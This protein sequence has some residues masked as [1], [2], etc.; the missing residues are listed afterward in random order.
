MFNIFKKG[1]KAKESKGNLPEEEVVELKKERGSKKQE[2]KTKE[3]EK[4]PQN[5]QQN[6]IKT[7]KLEKELTK[8]WRPR[9]IDV[10]KTF[11]KDEIL[12]SKTDTRGNLT[13]GNELFVKL[14][15]YPQDD[16]LGQPH[17]M[18]RHP[19][20]PKLIFKALWD[21]VAQGKEIN[22]FVVNLAKGGEYYWVFANVTPSFD[23]NGNIIG[24]YSVRRKP[25]PKA[26]EVI[27]PFYHDLKKAEAVGG[28]HESMKLLTN[29]LKSKN[30]SY[31]E[32]IYRLQYES[33]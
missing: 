10:E 33:F 30:M 6:V 2:A 5:E 8:I 27:K 13:Y 24:Y 29:L 4:K 20:M 21:T 16:L 1:K 26:L 23:K 17:S 19:D 22:A 9:P 18:I 28:M 32:L 7:P 12:V 11:A 14:A 31:E 3:S 25:S 15:G